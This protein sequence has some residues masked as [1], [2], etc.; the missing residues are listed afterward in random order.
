MDNSK[1]RLHEVFFYGLYMDEEILKSKGIEIRNQRAAYLKNYELKIGKLAT[2]H[3]VKNAKA[4][5]L[6]YSLTHKEIYSLYEGAGL[7]QYIQEAVLVQTDDNKEVVALTCI[8]LDDTNN[9]NINEEYRSKLIK[10]M[11]KYKLPIENK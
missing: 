9:G 4:Y 1:N 8:L 6:V 7:K 2:L 3:R 10:C 5:G 11:N